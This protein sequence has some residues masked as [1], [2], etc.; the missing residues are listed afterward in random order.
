MPQ[1]DEL[2]RLSEQLGNLQD[3]RSHCFLCA[4]DLAD[5]KRTDEHVIPQWAQRRYELWN[6]QLSLLNGTGI[7]YRRLTVP[8]CEDCNK[9]R[10]A[11]LED[12]LS[13]TVEQGRSAVLSLGHKLISLWLGKIFYGILYREMMLSANRSDPTSGTIIPP[14][15]LSRYRMHRFFLQQARGAVQLNDFRVGSLFIFDA[16]PLPNRKLEWDLIDNVE[17]LFISVRVG[18]VALFAALADGGA[19]QHDEPIYSEF[20]AMPLHP[21][22]IRELCARFCYR[23]L[24]T[25]RTPKYVT[26]SGSPHQT[27]QL[28]LGGLSSKPLFEAFDSQTYAQILSHFIGYPLDVVFRRPNAVMSWLRNDNGTMRYMPYKEHPALP[29][30][31]SNIP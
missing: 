29:P 9:Y 3:P 26:A 12:S 16:Q 10:L 14:E 2:E 1:K 22:Q 21:F 6:Q 8:C 13:Q 28:P 11:P 27:W 25:T 31:P 20:Y 7:Q 5:T 24:C 17:T 19:Q 30:G 4:K 15:V 23:S 18:R